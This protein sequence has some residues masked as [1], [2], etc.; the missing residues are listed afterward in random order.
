M[1]VATMDRC[2]QNFAMKDGDSFSDFV[3]P[4]LWRYDTI[5]VEFGYSR[6]QKPRAHR[7]VTS[8]NRPRLETHL[9]TPN[10]A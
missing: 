8:T 4:K 9:T 6:Q 1:Q 7:Y 3:L 10:H 5:H 2:A